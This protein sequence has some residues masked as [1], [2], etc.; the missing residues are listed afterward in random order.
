[1]LSAW[2]DNTLTVVDS[3]A[4]APY[5]EPVADFMQNHVLSVVLI[6]PADDNASH[7]IFG[8]NVRGIREMG[9]TFKRMRQTNR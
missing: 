9:D 6:K 4:D 2:R 3:L 1:M 8:D 7:S 5:P